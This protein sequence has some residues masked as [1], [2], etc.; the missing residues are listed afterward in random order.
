MSTA[1]AV[2]ATTRMAATREA[3]GVFAA[4]VMPRIAA[5]A[6]FINRRVSM[7]MVERRFASCRD[8]SVV[9]VMRIV[10]VVDVPVKPMMAVEPGASSDEN[11][12][13]KPVRPIV[14]IRR[15]VVGRIV[16]IAI[17]ANWRLANAD[18]YLCG[19]T[20]RPAQHSRS[21]RRKSK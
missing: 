20:S 6:M 1:A 19:C 3:G 12:A 11:P 18:S 5:T 16:E 17:G 21:E 7:E 14:T 4:S 15:T 13:I 2:S 9:T 10:T 8:G